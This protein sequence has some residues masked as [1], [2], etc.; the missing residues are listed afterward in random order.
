M[1]YIDIIILIILAFSVL[2]G[3]FRG[4]IRAVFDIMA[5]VFAI[6][7]GVLWYRD[8]SLYLT[9][10]MK[11]PGNIIYTIAFVLIFVGVYLATTFAGGFL[12]KIVGR[13][14]LGP[15]NLTGGA[16]IGLAKGIL[17]ILVILQIAVLFPL[18]KEA[19]SHINS[20]KG[21][22]ALMPGLEYTSRIIFGIVPKDIGDI[23]KYI[24]KMQGSLEAQ[25]I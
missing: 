11:L 25:E 13:G 4:L 19:A 18:P 6:W 3:L 8:L 15:L 7:L 12:H 10:F 22:Q 16:A 5:F 2:R 17:I 20:S 24:P 21:V 14:I 9:N 23:E 1:N